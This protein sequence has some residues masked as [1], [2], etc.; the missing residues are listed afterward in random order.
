MGKRSRLAAVAGTAIGIAGLGVA[1]RI[2]RWARRGGADEGATDALAPA[3]EGNRSPA[4]P[5]PP[6]DEAHA[7]GHRHLSLR[8]D[9]RDER[10][11]RPVRARP[12]A[13]H[14]R[15]LRHPGRG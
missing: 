12:F 9:V 15:G 4:P 14:Q 7:P 13:K 6:V 10:A 8:A 2:W 11:P 3:V 1:R 5:R